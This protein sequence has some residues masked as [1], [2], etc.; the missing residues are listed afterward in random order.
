MF[1][2]KLVFLEISVPLI[3]TGNEVYVHFSPS[4][5]L[6]A[7]VRNADVLNGLTFLHLF[8][9]SGRKTNNQI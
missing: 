8:Q 3:K 2:D 7:N 4:Q 9:M 5:L 1:L 6:C